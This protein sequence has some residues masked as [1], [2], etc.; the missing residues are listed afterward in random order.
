MS[1]HTS[2][3]VSISFRRYS[4]R[5]I[6]DAMRQTDLSCIE[7]GSDIHAPCRDDAKL[8]ELAKLQNEYGVSCCSYGTYFRLCK[9]DLCELEYYANAA[10]ILGTNTLRIWCGDKRREL[11][12]EDEKTELIKTSER[13]VCLAQKLDITL[14]MECHNNSY[15]E[16]LDGAL[17]LM[18]IISSPNFLM[19]WQ[20]NQFAD[21]ET[22]IKYAKQISPYVKNIHVFNWQGTNKYPLGE[23]KDAWIKYLSCFEDAKTLLLE[24][25]PDDRIETLK[26]EAQALCDIIET[27]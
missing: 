8:H 10:K 4:P 19:Y 1:K 9:D 20:P 7:W 14:C 3:L 13:A 15:T 18:N 6:L 27:I 17:E 24:F 23:G 21:F 5:E 26:I 22:N 2:G 25:M 16:T 11:C 12:S